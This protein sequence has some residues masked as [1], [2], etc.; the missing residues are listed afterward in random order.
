MDQ[1]GLRDLL[2]TLAAQA[3]SEYEKILLERNSK[4]EEITL[5][6]H[7]MDEL[8]AES[9][10]SFF[11]PRN[12]LSAYDEKITLEQDYKREKMELG[13]LDGLLD[14]MLNRKEELI[15][16]VELLD[17][18]IE[19]RDEI[20]KKL[21]DLEMSTLNEHEDSTED[22]DS[23]NNKMSIDDFIPEPSNN[24]ISTEEKNKQEEVED[25]FAPDVKQVL[26]AL[27]LVAYQCGEIANYTIQDPYRARNELRAISVKYG[28]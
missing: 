15:E 18:I 11:S 13:R 5:I 14:T 3:S 12:K 28:N 27:S 24:T 6:S 1:A 22:S 21:N 2:L 8:K 20:A 19:E 26:D 23:S 7:K 25:I 16:G 10:D 17:S 4:F 9:D